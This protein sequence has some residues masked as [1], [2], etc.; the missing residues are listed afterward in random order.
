MQ[1]ALEIN[2]KKS[3]EEKQDEKTQ[4]TEFILLLKAQKS[5]ERPI[6]HV[7]PG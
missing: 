4:G 7:C 5:R 1:F 2:D 6:F 3:R